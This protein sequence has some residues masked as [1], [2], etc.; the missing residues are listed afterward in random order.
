MPFDPTKP[1]TTRDGRAVRI[2]ATD[3]RSIQPIVALVEHAPDDEI[4]S[5]DQVESVEQFYQ[6]GR[7]RD[8]GEC[9]WDLVNFSTSI[10]AMA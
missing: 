9:G 1:C 10:M 4:P 6:D 7:F 8:G 3:A 5:G 2:L